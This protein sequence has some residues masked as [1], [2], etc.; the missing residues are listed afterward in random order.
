M[1]RKEGGNSN[2]NM[3]PNDRVISC[4]KNPVGKHGTWCAG[5]IQRDDATKI[6]V[7]R[8]GGKAK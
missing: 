1:Y 8:V 3:N 7:Y 6:Q 5:H 4:N 2:T